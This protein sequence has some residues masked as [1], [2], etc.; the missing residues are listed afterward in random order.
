MVLNALLITL[1][2]SFSIFVTAVI[3]QK[4]L[5]PKTCLYKQKAKVDCKGGGE[6][7][8]YLYNIFEMF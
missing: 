1:K 2:I 8:L 5:Q 6:G 7:M 4:F 3:G